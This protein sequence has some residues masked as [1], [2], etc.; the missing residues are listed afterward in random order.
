MLGEERLREDRLRPSA[1]FPA[2]P[3]GSAPAQGASRD[4]SG[5]P[6]P[7]RAPAE[8]KFAVGSALGWR[9][10]AL[11]GAVLRG[12]HRPPSSRSS[13]PSLPSASCTKVVAAESPSPARS[14]WWCHG[15][16]QQVLDGAELL[17]GGGRFPAALPA[18]QAAP[19]PRPARV[20][21]VAAP[22]SRARAGAP[23]VHSPPSAWQTSPG[24]GRIRRREG[25]RGY[26]QAPMSGCPRSAGSPAFRVP[27]WPVG[28]PRCTGK[29]E[30]FL[31]RPQA[32]LGPSPEDS[33]SYSRVGGGEAVCPS[34]IQTI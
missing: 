32:N 30:N 25:G 19:R 24:A 8:P 9:G 23:R 16:L 28:P 34:V 22:P 4:R 5:L 12:R 17:A 14:P 13:P 1:A 11:Q 29:S 7:A 15:G 2:T 33:R 21:F 6:A 31:L 3:W 10:G 26:S 18:P 20:R 27:R